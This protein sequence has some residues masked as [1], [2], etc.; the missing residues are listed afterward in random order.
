MTEVHANQPPQ[1]AQVS[2]PI[3]PVVQPQVDPNRPEGLPSQFQDVQALADAYKSLQATYTQTQQGILPSQQQ[4][5]AQPG[6]QPP[7]Q[8]GA[9]P[10]APQNPLAIQPP[11]PAGAE[12]LFTQAREEFYAQGDL[13]PQTRQALAQAGV[14]EQIVNQYLQGVEAQYNLALNSV[15]NVVGGAEQF[16]QM[17]QWA[18]VTLEPRVLQQF[19]EVMDSGN[20]AQIDMVVR[21]LHAQYLAAN[22]QAP[23]LIQGTGESA[24]VDS[25]RD[26]NELQNDINDPRYQSDPAFRKAVDD[27]LSRSAANFQ[28]TQYGENGQEVSVRYG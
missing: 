23:N 5:Q 18:S 16:A 1:P 12:Q 11:T 25:Y 27:K 15:H 14:S 9:Q 19:N 3:T 20:L 24:P 22:P 4:P 17:Q 2:Q 8:P 28:V 6:A 7:A 26:Q 13:S 10:Q 21:G